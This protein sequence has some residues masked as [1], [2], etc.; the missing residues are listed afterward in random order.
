MSW[1]WCW[2]AASCSHLAVGWLLLSFCLPVYCAMQRT[3]VRNWFRI[4]LT[5]RKMKYSLHP[6]QLLGLIHNEGSGVFVWHRGS[7]EQHQPQVQ[8]QCWCPVTQSDCVSVTPVSAEGMSP[9]L[10]PSLVT[11]P[12]PS[13]REQSNSKHVMIFRSL[14]T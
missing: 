9:F 12:K 4:K 6:E 7:V 3:R 2:K 1:H 8:W 5:Q 11:A 13:K 10:F 14:Q